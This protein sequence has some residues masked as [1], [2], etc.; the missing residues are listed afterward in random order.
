[1]DPC[2]GPGCGTRESAHVGE[3]LH[4]ASTAI[5][6]A[7]A[8]VRGTDQGGCLGTI[9]QICVSAPAAPL[10]DARTDRH[11]LALGAGGLDP[12][13]AHRVAIDAVLSDQIEHQVRSAANGLDDFRAQLR[14]EPC[15]QLIRI[16]FD[17]GDDLAAVEARGTL[18][19]IHCLEHDNVAAEFSQVQRGR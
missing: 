16:V 7:T 11:Q 10:L 19:D 3:R 1:V 9:E 13:R 8:V 5:D 18:A 14:S 15:Q 2:T 12:A 17:T 4:G 6:P